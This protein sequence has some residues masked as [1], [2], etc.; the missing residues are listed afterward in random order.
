M[1]WLGCLVP[2]FRIWTSTVLRFC[3]LLPFRD[4]RSAG[5]RTHR[6]RKLRSTVP[7]DHAIDLLDSLAHVALILDP[8]LCVPP[9]GNASPRSLVEKHCPRHL[10]GPVRCVA[11]GDHPLSA[12]GHVSRAS[13]RRAS[14]DS[15]GP[16]QIRLGARSDVVAALF[17]AA[18]HRLCEPRLDLF[19]REL[20]R[21]NSIHVVG[22]SF[23][24][25]LWRA[26]FQRE[27]LSFSRGTLG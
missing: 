26:L 23:V 17:L 21:P 22:T 12:L 24:Y 10:D 1:E 2:R 14:P 6:S 18:N 3:R 16:A 25:P 11:Q 27:F 5:S 15:T 20:T 7:I 4:R 9:L 19:P 8:R 13:A